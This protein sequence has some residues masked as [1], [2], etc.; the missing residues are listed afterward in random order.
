M[1][2]AWCTPRRT[3]E[4]WLSGGHSWLALLHSC[5]LSNSADRTEL[6][7][8]T[9]TGSVKRTQRVLF[10][11]SAS[12]LHGPT[13]SSKQNNLGICAFILCISFGLPFPVWVGEKARELRAYTAFQGNLSSVPS[14]NIRLLRRFPTISLPFEFPGD[15]VPL[16]CEQPHSFVLPRPRGHN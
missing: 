7:R 1:V 2:D 15:V 8:N 4:L 3:E 13:D 5:T 11:K 10:Q 9:S 6:G 14:T 16:P 12:S